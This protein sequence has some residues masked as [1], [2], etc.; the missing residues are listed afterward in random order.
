M[1]G[2]APNPTH[3]FE[4]QA[5]TWFESHGGVFKTVS[6]LS[7]VGGWFLAIIGHRYGIHNRCV[8]R[9]QQYYAMSSTCRV[10]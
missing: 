3:K 8:M 5:T 7:N 2:T 4:D 6:T 1:E 9:S 10:W